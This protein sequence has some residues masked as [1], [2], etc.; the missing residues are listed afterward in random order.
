[1][2]ERFIAKY[3]NANVPRTTED[4]EFSYLATWLI[5]QRVKYRHG[6]LKKELI[7]KLEKMGVDFDEFRETKTIGR[8]E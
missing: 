5:Y 2:L 4:P 6:L 3:G 1:M 8:L 7:H